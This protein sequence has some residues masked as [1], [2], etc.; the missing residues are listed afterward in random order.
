MDKIVHVIDTLNRGGTET[1]L[2]SLL[3]E[4]S[5]KYKIILVT[6]SPQN[7]FGEEALKSCHRYY[8]LNHK[9]SFSFFSSIYKLKAIIK[10]HRPVLVRAQLIWSS[11]ITRI[12]CPHHIPLIFSVHAT[13]ED[14]SL[15]YKGR[16]LALLERFTLN[17]KQTM[18]GVTQTVVVDY[19]KKF[20]FKG[21][22]YTVYN[23]IREE[24]FLNKKKKVQPANHLCLVAVGNLKE[25]KNYQYI[26]EAFK[27]I[28]NCN[29]SLDIYGEGH[30][31][32]ELQDQI[33]KHNLAINLKGKIPNVAE[34]LQQY[35]ALVMTSTYEG[36]ANAAVEAMAYGLPLI[37]SDLPSLRE[38]TG[39]N[40]VFV[41]LSSPASL[42]NVIKGVLSNKIDINK[43]TSQGR[44]LAAERY[45][46]NVGVNQ[47]LNVYQETIDRFKKR[48]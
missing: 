40:A 44:K 33:A 24:F 16:V 10:E 1:F 22:H 30:L 13:T 14:F 12:A 8:C 5:K 25:A 28:G 34:V 20:N 31:R 23:Y 29:V 46:K 36:F 43:Y 27:D 3:P 38:V 4:L 11:I 2:V 21:P 41:D 26:I 47:L 17:S 18:I 42:V 6:L 7:D 48:P 32:Q 37:L 39:N 35:D 45:C 9:G 19:V 15:N